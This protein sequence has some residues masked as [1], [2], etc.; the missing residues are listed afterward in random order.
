MAGI[1]KATKEN[2][3]HLSVVVVPTDDA[4]N[5][6]CHYYPRKGWRNTRE[7]WEDVF[8]LLSETVE[9]D[10]TLADAVSRGLREEL[11]AQGEPEVFLGSHSV[12]VPSRWGTYQKTLLFF[13]V[14]VRSGRA[15]RSKELGAKVILLPPD[16]LLIR[17]RAQRARGIGGG[18]DGLEAIERYCDRRTAGPN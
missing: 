9:P 2:P 5:V 1:F 3:Y 12:S 6:A 7:S 8:L 16:E 11:S 17:M 4:G 14:R 13:R 10:E 15:M 18:V